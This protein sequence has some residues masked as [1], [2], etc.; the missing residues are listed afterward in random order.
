M[1]Q[2]HKSV[3]TWEDIYKIESEHP[4]E[5]RKV[6]HELY[7]E[8]TIIHPI[9]YSDNPNEIHPLAKRIKISQRSFMKSVSFL[10]V[11]GLIEL[12]G[13]LAHIFI[14][15]K[16]FDIAREEQ[17]H[18][19]N[20]TLQTIIIYLTTIIAITTAFELFNNLKIIDALTLFISYLIS[21]I[22]IVYFSVFVIFRRLLR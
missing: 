11:N 1:I 20:A 2:K 10:K 17:N 4:N 5:W 7:K 12:K 14:T 3:S 19:L 15:P 21:T 6:L 22:I 8:N 16:G 13:K 9:N 18:K